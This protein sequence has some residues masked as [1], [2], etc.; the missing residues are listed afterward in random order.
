MWDRRCVVLGKM[1]KTA[2]GIKTTAARLIALSK[3]P[4]PFEMDRLEAK[5]VAWACFCPT[6]ERRQPS[7]FRRLGWPPQRRRAAIRV[8]AP[9]GRSGLG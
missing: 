3:V 1:H 7:V 5:V 6:G 4:L 2:D 9:G 8:A